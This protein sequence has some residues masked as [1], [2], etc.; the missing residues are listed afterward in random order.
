MTKK[1][2]R[3]CNHNMS[4][5]CIIIE[6]CCSLYCQGVNDF[7]FQSMFNSLFSEEVFSS[8]GTVYNL[9][10]DSKINQKV[11]LISSTGV[12]T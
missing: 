7:L 12:S 3:Y 11:Y 10:D 9:N 8:S 2:N 1:R 5:T 6:S 4:R